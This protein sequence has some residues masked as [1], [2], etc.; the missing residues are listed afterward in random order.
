[1]EEKMAEE[2]LAAVAIRDY[3]SMEVAVV[4]EEEL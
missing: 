1:M 2:V 3:L 4:E